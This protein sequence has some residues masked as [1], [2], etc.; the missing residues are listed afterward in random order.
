MKNL[1]FVCVL[2]ACGKAADD[3]ALD[4]ATTGITDTSA[5]TDDTSSSEVSCPEGEA[6]VTNISPSELSAM[7]ESKDF[8]LI[9]V[10]VPYA[11]E[12]VGTDESISY[13]KGGEIASYLNDDITAPVVLY[14]LT[15]PMSAIA[16]DELLGKG[17]CNVYDMPA[18][19]VGWEDSGYA[20]ERN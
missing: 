4:S 1:I 13:R 15:G 17:F 3:T 16:A 8:A 2:F 18:G 19:M 20:T 9:N 7:M 11:G 5:V 12:I 10:H 6:T 14:C